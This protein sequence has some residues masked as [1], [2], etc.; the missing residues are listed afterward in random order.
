MGNDRKKKMPMTA[1]VIRCSFCESQGNEKNPL[2]EGK[3]GGSSYI[4]TECVEALHRMVQ[5]HYEKNGGGFK[6][7]PTPQTICAY[8]D[9]F[10]I[11]QHDAK[12]ALSVAVFNH[13][14]RLAHIDSRKRGEVELDK[15]NILLIGPTGCG[16]TLLAK[17]LAR[18]LQVPI[19]IG[20]AT[21]LTEAGYVGEDV[22]NLLLKLIRA[23][24]NKIEDA[25]R[26]IIVIDEIDKLKKS[27]GNVSI[28]RDVGGE[29]VQQSLLKMIEGTVCNVPPHG[30][31]KHPEQECIPINTSNILFI[32]S[33]SFTGLFDI[34]S[35]RIG[36]GRLG[37]QTKR[38]TDDSNEFNDVMKQVTEEDLIEFGLIP[39]LIGRLPIVVTL[40]ELNE[41]QMLEIITTP[42]NA[43]VKQYQK[44][45]ELAKDGTRI[46][47]TESALLRVVKKALEKGTGARALR[48]VFEKFM[49]DIMFALPDQEPGSYIV[50]E[51][52]VDGTR[53]LFD[54]VASETAA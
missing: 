46:S 45:V 21:T 13:Y 47:F 43:I 6:G 4:C 34:I 42:K 1:K 14:R 7:A 31:R 24:D 38:E 52:V 5:A 23:A 2:I 29:G 49:T 28:T 20:D 32:V 41:I 36:R 27:G 18:R 22:E 33:G 3:V 17:T 44:M 35:K 48:S 37:F 53:S 19:A 10:V 9:Q 54:K 50:D 39:E 40:E 12:K 51:Q 16:K 25:Q 15:S 8:L 11:G 26:G 30:G